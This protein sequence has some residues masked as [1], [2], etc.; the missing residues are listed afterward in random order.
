MKLNV[1]NALRHPKEV[2]SSEIDMDLKEAV[3]YEAIT[4]LHISLQFV[5]DGNKITVFGTA[6]IEIKGL[7]DRCLQ[8]TTSKICFDFKENFFEPENLPDEDAYEID[9]NFVDLTEPMNNFLEMNMPMKFLCSEN[10]KGLCKICGHNL[11]E[12]DCE[13]VIKD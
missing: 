10:C 9:R 1:I 3:G 12:S 2:F 8:E 4:P 11:N 7:C 13:H 5:Y 6:N